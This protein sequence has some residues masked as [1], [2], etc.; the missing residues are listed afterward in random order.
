MKEKDSSKFLYFNNEEL[1]K[2]ETD[3][4]QVFVTKRL[5]GKETHNIKKQI[6]VEKNN[7]FKGKEEIKEKSIA[8][9]LVIDIPISLTN[10]ESSKK[11]T[12]KR[13][14]KT[15]K[16][17]IRKNNN[18]SNDKT[19]KKSTKQSKEKVDRDN[20]IDIKI[21][22]IPK[23]KKEDGNSRKNVKSR[24]KQE[25]QK[26]NKN[27]KKKN[28][29]GKVVTIIIL[30][31]AT[32][33]VTFITPIFNITKIEVIGNKNITEQTVV[34]LS[35]LKKGENI[36][37]NLKSNI[38]K[39][40]KEN[41]YIEDVQVKRVLPG[42][43]KIN[44]SERDIAYQIKVLESY[45]YIDKQGYILEIA[46]EEKNVP[47]IEE[48]DTKD[49]DILKSKRLDEKDLLKLNSIQ[50]IINS[51]KAIQ[52]EEKIDKINIKDNKEYIVYI[53]NKEIYLGDDLN[54]N[55]KM[56]YIQMILND[57]GESAGI[58]FVNGDFNN[59]FKAYFRPQE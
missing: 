50:K 8:E 53:G 10:K 31:V 55:N 26:K 3:N 39:N 44:I 35:R 43:I 18:K 29:L 2:E 4:K 41:T 34:S 45:A 48:Y 19:N 11:D 42:T 37:K 5:S 40:I 24:K 9:E 38:I 1:E 54:L 15:P 20:V 22:R 13:N 52:I 14:A 36:F 16:K 59:G 6:K 57:V 17:D 32:L 49:D 33:I 7:K 56:G 30:I 46:K 51:A 23:S 21:D 47:F 12:K 58:I 27:V 25:E 28:F